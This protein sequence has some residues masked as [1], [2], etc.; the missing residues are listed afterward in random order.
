[1]P[2]KAKPSSLDSQFIGRISAARMLDCSPQLID[3]MIRANTL[4]AFRFGRK[5]LLRRD[6]LLSVL[7]PVEIKEVRR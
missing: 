2:E 4:R 6:E 1:M 5:I 7:Q 3:K